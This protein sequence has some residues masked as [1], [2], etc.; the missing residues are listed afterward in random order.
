MEQMRDRQKDRWKTDSLTKRQSDR[1]TD[2][3]SDIWRY[4][5]ADKDIDRQ[6]G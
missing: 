4:R 5:Q 2:S 3:Q 1:E 6:T